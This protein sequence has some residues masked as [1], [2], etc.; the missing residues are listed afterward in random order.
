MTQLPDFAPVTAPDET[1]REHARALCHARHGAEPGLGHP[2][3]SLGALEPLGGWVAACQAS[4]PP[5]PIEA[6][7]LI[8]VAGDQEVARVHP[9]ISSL[10]PD[11]TQQVKATIRDGQAPIASAARATGVS[12]S[13][14]DA[15][16]NQPGGNIATAD[17]LSETQVAECIQQG[18]RVADTE[19]DEGTQVL[20]LGD[21]GR[22][23]TTPAA[24]VV[25]SLCGLEPIKVV[26]RGAGIG[27]DAWRVKV[28]VLRDAMYRV[29][30][31]RTDALQVIRR[32][33]S[34]EIAVL[35]GI[36]AQAAV[37]RT[38]V[39]FDGVACAAAALCA[40]HLAP[41]AGAWWQAATTGS[42]PASQ[43]V[44][45]ALQLSPLLN[46]RLGTGQGLGAVMALPL[47]RCAAECFGA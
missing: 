5:Q 26:G 38:P 41:G 45:T 14:V 30:D 1:L 37:R 16:L 47:L 33:G 18:I 6:A 22:G 19:A 9:E 13:V 8:I 43:V 25:G 36:L 42:E 17:A 15:S 4:A 32:V 29:R 35:T 10:P 27:D 39:I 21:L 28:A 7:R 20:L 40:Q 2:P 24:A 34:A 12:L 11:Y 46:L 44:H 23:L 31:D 3:R